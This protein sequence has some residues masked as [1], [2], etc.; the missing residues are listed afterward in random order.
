[1][2]TERR[3]DVDWLRVILFGLL[4]WF[5]YAVFSLGIL[6][7]NRGAVELGWSFPITKKVKGYVQYFN[8]YGECLVDYNDT[9]NRI[10]VGVMLN[11]WI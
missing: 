6:F 9:A 4:I 8:G 2:N 3:Y 5:H 10:G 11:D 1:M 7:E